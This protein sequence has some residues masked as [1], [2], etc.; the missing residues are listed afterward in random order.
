MLKMSRED[1]G[2]R[3]RGKIRGWDAVKTACVQVQSRRA[4]TA[5]WESHRKPCSQLHLPG[6]LPDSPVL[7][8]LSSGIQKDTFDV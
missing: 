5:S 3:G 2:Q 7:S 1:R 6:N 4:G 8:V